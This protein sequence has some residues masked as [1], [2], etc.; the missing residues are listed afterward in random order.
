[1]CSRGPP[2]TEVLSLGSFAVVISGDGRL[3]QAAILGRQSSGGSVI[4]QSDNRS[5]RSGLKMAQVS[6]RHR[7]YVPKQI[8][9]KW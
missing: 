5:G 1:M 4:L 6:S 9:V 3:R 2:P 7:L 8:S